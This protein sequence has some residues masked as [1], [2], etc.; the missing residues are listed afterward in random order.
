[1]QRS[2]HFLQEELIASEIAAR[3]ELDNIPTPEVLSHLRVLAEGLEKV[4]LVLGEK[5]IH[6]NSG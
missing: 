1:M 3:S 4:R 2:E 6:V 5:P